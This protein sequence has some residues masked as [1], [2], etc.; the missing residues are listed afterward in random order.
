MDFK[1]ISDPV[2]IVSEKPK[3]AG[4]FNKIR[5]PLTNFKISK[6]MGGTLTVL[7]LF[8]VG[9][10]VYL[11]QK[12]TQLKPQAS[13]ANAEISLKPQALTVA[14]NQEFPASVFLDSKDLSITAIQTKVIFDQS[15]LQLLEVGLNDYLTTVLTQPQNTANST[16]FAVGSNEGKKGS[17]IIATMRFKAIGTPSNTPTIIQFDQQLTQGAAL[18]TNDLNALSIYSASHITIAQIASPSASASPVSCQ[19]NDQCPTGYYC[20]GTG[21]ACTTGPI[22]QET[23]INFGECQPN[24]TKPSPNN[25][26]TPGSKGDGNSDGIIDYA[27]LSILFSKWSPAVDITSNFQVDFNDDKRINSF[28]SLKMNDLLYSLGVIKR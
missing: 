25:H 8:A 12:P 3:R 14:P 20:Q 11:A 21:G 4:L 24:S 15:K 18:E 27:D 2:V 22:G 9:V 19:N 26:V 5:P 10:G 13:E 6:V 1:G 16:F 7:L 28:D 17:G 23:C